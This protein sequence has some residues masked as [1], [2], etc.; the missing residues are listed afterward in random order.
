MPDGVKIMVIIDGSGGLSSAECC[1]DRW[2]TD[3]D[4]SSFRI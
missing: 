4:L 2:R 1:Q 3:E